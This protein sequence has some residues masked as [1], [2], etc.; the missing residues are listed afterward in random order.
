MVRY[1]NYRGNPSNGMKNHRK[2]K[3]AKARKEEA[4]RKRMRIQYEE[5]L[6]NIEKMK[7]AKEAKEWESRYSY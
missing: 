4:I 1:A 6:K 3:L 5:R 2:R 7:Y